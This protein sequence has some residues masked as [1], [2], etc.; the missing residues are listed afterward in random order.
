[1]LFQ[2]IFLSAFPFCKSRLFSY[3]QQAQL[4]LFPFRSNTRR[5]R[6]LWCPR[7]PQFTLILNTFQT[8]A[9]RYVLL[10]QI[11][12]YSFPDEQPQ[13]K[14]LFSLI[15][16]N[17]FQFVSCIID[18]LSNLE[19]VTND[20]TVDV[21]FFYQSELESRVARPCKTRRGW[22]LCSNGWKV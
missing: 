9:K 2:H 20:N 21:F 18:M 14:H 11:S 3:N 15:D 5:M 12:F 17:E 7:K 19:S 10:M 6:I 1:M 13:C 8:P 22:H 4:Q 16:S